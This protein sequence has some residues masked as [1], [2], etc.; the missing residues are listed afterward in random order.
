ML[1]GASRASITALPVD[2]DARAALSAAILCLVCV[3]WPLLAFDGGLAFNSLAGLAALFMLGSVRHFRP[4]WYMA[5]FVGFFVYAAISALWSPRPFQLVEIDFAKHAFNMRSEVVRVGLTFLALAVVLTAA[6]NMKEGARRIV[7]RFVT[8][9]LLVQLVACVVLALFEK[10]ALDLFAPLMADSGEGIQ[11]ISRNNLIMA[12][13]APAL[14]FNLIENRSRAMAILIA[15]V[16]IGLE[17]GVLFA[18]G[19]D[20]GLLVLVAAILSVVAIRLFPKHGFKLIAGGVASL[21]LVAPLLFGFISRG[22]NASLETTSAGYREAIWRRVMEVIES[23]P[24][25]G[26]G[27]G[28]LRTI[29]EKIPDGVFAGNLLVPNHAHNMTLQLWAETGA[30]GAVLLSLAIFL[31]G[32]RLPSPQAMGR[33]APRVAGLIAGM[34]VVAC[35]SFDLW[36]EWWWAVGGLLAVFAAALPAASASSPGK[37]VSGG[38]AALDGQAGY[39]TP[40][41]LREASAAIASRIGGDG[42]CHHA[43]ARQQF[44]SAA[45]GFR[46]DGGGLPH[47]QPRWRWSMVRRW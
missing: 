41:A 7:S 25:T 31:A 5:A 34:T 28:V 36:R 11:N 8:G 9:A 4:R 23:H 38:D 43:K 6:L 37:D 29:K 1:K 30:I 10:Q 26:A 45:P 42:G 33:A 39:P 2:G 14:V 13:A 27:V 21:I 3:L 17:A 22:A 32:W 20:A 15:V 16:V 12:V 19:V 35:V 47:S 44:Q 18:R 24:V 46:F 40:E